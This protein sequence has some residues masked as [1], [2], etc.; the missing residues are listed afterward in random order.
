MENFRLK[1]LWN[2]TQVKKTIQKYLMHK[3]IGYFCLTTKKH[4]PAHKRKFKYHNTEA[5]AR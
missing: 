5:I 4:E 3:E 2:A 1:M